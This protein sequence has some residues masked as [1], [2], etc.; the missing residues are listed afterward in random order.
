MRERYDGSA[1]V[2]CDGIAQAYPK[3][4]DLDRAITLH[5][6]FLRFY[7]NRK[8]RKL[9]YPKYHYCLAILYEKKGLPEQ[10]IQEYQ[11]F[12]TIRK[13]ADEDISEHIDFK[14]KVVELNMFR[15]H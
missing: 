8:D 5:E 14:D 7:P 4:G 9:I 15:F 11:K 3:R 13:D 10:A 6:H 12:L 1:I 2:Y